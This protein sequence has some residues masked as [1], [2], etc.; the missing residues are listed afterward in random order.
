[1][2][3]GWPALG[4]AYERVAVHLERSAREY[5]AASRE[6]RGALQRALAESRLPAHAH[7]RS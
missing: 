4:R 5:V 7:R 2:E 6:V 1:M 3:R